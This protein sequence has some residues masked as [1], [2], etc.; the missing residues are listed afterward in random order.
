LLLL[1]FIVRNMSVKKMVTAIGTATAVVLL[2][3]P[4]LINMNAGT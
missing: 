1:Y 4:L 3:T 2:D